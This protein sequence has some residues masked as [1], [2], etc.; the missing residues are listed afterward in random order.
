MRAVTA[1][2]R[3]VVV[4]AA[5][6][7]TTAGA[8]TAATV[9]SSTAVS[10][11]VRHD[12]SRVCFFGVETGVVCDQQSEGVDVMRITSVASRQRKESL[13]VMRLEEGWVIVSGCRREG[14]TKAWRR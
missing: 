5:V 6:S 7:S 10:A 12:V 13:F 1:I 8:S 2:S 3:E 14:G 9:S 11:A 4:P